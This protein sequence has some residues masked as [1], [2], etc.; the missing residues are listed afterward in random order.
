MLLV[1]S[2][3]GSGRISTI[4]PR[5]AE[6]REKLEQ[7]LAFRNPWLLKP[8][9]EIRDRLGGSKGYVGVHARVGDGVF[10]S[11]APQNMERAW[12]D[13]VERLGVD[14]EVAEEM[15][16][17]VNSVV[18]E[19]KALPETRR[20]KKLAKRSPSFAERSLVPSLSSANSIEWSSVDNT[21]LY[22]AKLDDSTQS[23][24]QRRSILTAD[25]ALFPRDLTALVCRAPLHTSEALAAFNTPLY[26]AT[27]SR[28][29]ASD[30][31]LAIFFASFPC[32]FTLADFDRPGE[33]N[34]G[35]AVS[36]V[37]DMIKLVNGAD[38]VALGRLFLPF[39]EAIV[40]A[41]GF[42]TVGTFGSTFSG[43]C[44][45]APRH[46]RLLTSDV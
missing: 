9:N 32:T 19:G 16:E 36:S 34:D 26:L 14:P 27:D 8:A 28:S 46:I 39:L 23:P 18:E 4:D 10:K 41:K 44:E 17:K 40:A 30:P 37:G 15:W 35:L 33:L 29:P 43:K 13:L 25:L 6:L 20:I 1:G 38:G 45:Y 2:L 42:E 24:R 31:N 12:R 5:A 3:F 11:R 21:E 7:G 22:H